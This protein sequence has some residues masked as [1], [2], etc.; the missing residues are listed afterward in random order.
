MLP[1]MLEPHIPQCREPFVVASV[2][3]D[4]GYRPGHN[5]LP[6][7]S[8]SVV[9]AITPVPVPELSPGEN[10]LRGKISGRGR[11][12]KA[13]PDVRHFQHVHPSAADAHDER[14]L[15]VSGKSAE[16]NPDLCALPQ[17][18]PRGSLSRSWVLHRVSAAVCRTSGGTREKMQRKLSAIGCS[19]GQETGVNRGGQLRFGSGVHPRRNPDL[20][21]GS[22]SRRT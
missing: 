3:G 14:V 2:I 5:A 22:P 12:F 20:H 13:R 11:I 1:E 4:Q 18:T 16:D 10:R 21:G 9:A 7:T 15:T 8:G 17:A 19:Q 6:Q